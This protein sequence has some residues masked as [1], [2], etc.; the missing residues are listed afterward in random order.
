MR[1]IAW[2]AALAYLAQGAHLLIL[3]VLARLAFLCAAVFALYWGPLF[4]ASPERP[5]W[6]ILGESIR[7]VW[8]GPLSS[9]LGFLAVLLAWLLGF[10]SVGGVVLIVPALVALLQTEHY[11]HLARN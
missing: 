6:A 4:A 7:L 10:V 8:R 5:P 1:R 2:L 9:L 11:N 3:D